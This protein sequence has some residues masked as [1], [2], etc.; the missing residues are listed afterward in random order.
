MLNKSKG[1]MYPWVTHTWNPIKGRCPHQCRY[2]YMKKF[3]HKMK[4]PYFDEKCLKDN[5]GSGNIIFVGSSIDMWA[6]KIPLPWICN[7]IEYCSKFSDNTYLFQSKNPRRFINVL[8]LAE[9]RE[10]S[11][12]TKILFGTTIETNRFYY[13]LSDAPKPYDRYIAMSRIVLSDWKDQFNFDIM[14]S[15]EPIINFDL[16]EL[17]EWIRILQPK[18][19]SIGADSKG[20]NLPEPP[21][22]KVKELIEKLEE[23]TEVKIKKNLNRILE[24]ERCLKWK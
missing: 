18:F 23:F 11:L 21:A 22:W 7:V 5:L 8:K 1:N 14:I 15:I 12:P 9:W 17:V 20:N 10:L 2:C 19:V 13:G 6:K 16:E 4:E 3:W 24:G